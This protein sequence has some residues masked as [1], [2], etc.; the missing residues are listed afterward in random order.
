MNDSDDINPAFEAVG[1]YSV[2]T[3]ELLR[4]SSPAML[5]YSGEILE[6][7]SHDMLVHDG[8]LYI[9]TQCLISFIPLKIRP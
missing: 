7:F 4:R 3:I 1:Y 6:Q 9:K 2:F 8:K 5:V